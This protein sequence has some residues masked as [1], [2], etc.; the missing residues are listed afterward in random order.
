M[1]HLARAN[2]QQ[3]SID[4]YF[5]I[6][7]SGRMGEM[8]SKVYDA[9]NELGPSTNREL[10]KV[11]GTIPSSISPRIHELRYKF[12]VVRKSQKRVCKITGKKA[13][14]WELI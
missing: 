6:I 4:A 1:I 3:T 8:Q 12:Q 10:A 13:I 7:E 14:A 11:L 5:D 2:L 9:L